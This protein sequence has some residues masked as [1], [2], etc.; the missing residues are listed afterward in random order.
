MAGCQVVTQQD[1]LHEGVAQ[2]ICVL[3]S[4][5]RCVMLGE[6]LHVSY[7]GPASALI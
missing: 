5:L 6:G 1:V 7:V 4:F 3:I 2:Q